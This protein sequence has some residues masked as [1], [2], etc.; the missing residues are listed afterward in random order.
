MTGSRRDA[1]GAAAA[2]G[3]ALAVY[4]RTLAPGL[5]AVVDTPMFQF[6]GRVLGVPHNP[7]YP[8]Y[9]LLTHAFS[10]VPVG[11]LAYRINLF[12]A[13]CGAIAVALVFL[14]ARQLGCGGAIG[15]A[16]ALGFGFGHIFWSQSIVAEVYTL[17]AALVAAMLLLLLVWASTQREAIF[18]AAIAVFA[19]GLGN[20][21]T[22]VGFAPGIAVFGLMNNR[23]FVLRPRTIVISAG[24]VAAGLLQYAF[25]ILRSRHPGA[26]VESRATTVPELMRVM[27]GAQ[28]EE[29][30][31]S[32]EWQT[33]VFERIPWLVTRVL[34][35]EL[36]VVGL[37]LA[38]GGAAWLVRR[39][40]RVAVLLLAG[41]AATV[42][43][44]AN[45]NVVDTPVFLIPAILVFWLC[46][47]V[48]ME[49]LARLAR[50]ERA[51]VTRLAALALPIWLVGV[52]FSRTDRSHDTEAATQLAGLFDA[53]PDRSALVH[54]DFIVDR[55]VMFK[56]LGEMAAHGRRIDLVPRDAGQVL[57]LHRDGVN[58]QAFS[59]SARR[60]RYE[61]LDFRFAPQRV[62]G[63]RLPEVLARLQEGSVVA[64]TASADDAAQVAGVN[65]S[66][67]ARLGVAGD[68]TRTTPGHLVVVGVAG[69]RRGAIV[70]GSD[71]EARATVRPGELPG[72]VVLASESDIEL[73]AGPSDAVIG[74]GGRDLVRTA[75]GAAVAIWNPDG[76]L[77]HAFV[78]ARP[79]F[80][81]PLKTGALS[82]YPLRGR[83]SSEAIGVEWTDLRASVRTGSTMFRVGAG[84]TV[85]LYCGDARP[86]APRAIDRSSNA[87]RVEVT[88]VDDND[89]SALWQVPHRYKVEVASP[90]GAGSVL[91]AFG[92][93]PAY[94]AARVTQPASAPATAFSVETTG[95]LRSPDR[96][97]EVLLMARDEQAQLTGAG[98]SAVEADAV[99]PFRWLTAP[100]ARLVLPLAMDSARAIRI[101]ARYD[102]QPADAALSVRL[103]DV[104][105][106]PQVL[107]SG[108]STYEWMVAP[109]TLRP[110]TNEAMLL[111]D[112]VGAG[113][114]VA[115]ADVRVIR[116]R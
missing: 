31:F 86:L 40:P 29:R 42:T 8:L 111:L 32:F 106:P 102:Q 3:A 76:R 49:Q 45:Y 47:A 5:V 104:A 100:E 59:R 44:A 38:V 115:I 97:S 19:G 80:R 77:E 92:G 58:V 9:V 46:A 114:G 107:R 83:W 79:E 94:A 60:L 71:R 91:L 14:I 33:V 85:V 24:I 68:L 82:V 48:A 15:L 65:G 2:G 95:L 11:S 73:R 25:I 51:R 53:L 57:G 72:G 13:L 37:L 64:I 26:Y 90:S 67:L 7:G 74:W 81:A 27:T 50:G 105:L 34:A 17:N 54:E 10:Y 39:R 110:G 35:P 52:N 20:H 116:G 61:G 84:G 99:T 6:V 69:A 103:N 96:S 63:G 1:L 87:L 30:L 112:G 109:G 98:W 70:R 88:P 16:A 62:T 78:L 12:S 28:F 43:F 4:L 56:L 66:Q 21:T 55:M 89:G 36:T 22:I 18:F 23:A 101:Q 108:W 93:V 41:C 113:R 75:E